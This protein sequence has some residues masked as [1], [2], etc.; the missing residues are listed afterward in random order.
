MA[1]CNIRAILQHQHRLK[2]NTQQYFAH[3]ILI[4]F[5][6]I[7]VGFLLVLAIQWD[8]S[9]YNFDFD[10]QFMISHLISL[11]LQC[12]I[13]FYLAYVLVRSSQA[14]AKIQDPFLNKSVSLIVYL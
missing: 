13:V 6:M 14:V 9:L 7:D 3:I 10:Q 8:A 12:L 11:S 2:L 1:L 5:F 4:M